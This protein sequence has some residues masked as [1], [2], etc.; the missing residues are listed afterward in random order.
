MSKHSQPPDTPSKGPRESALPEPMIVP[1]ARWVPSLVW[2]ILLVAASIS[3]GLAVKSISNRGPAI[4]ISFVNAEGLEPGK[5]KV[6]Y[7]D[8]NIGSVE[9]I[10]LSKDRLRVLV[11]VQLRRK[12]RNSQSRARVSGP[13]ARASP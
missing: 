4:T 5:S 8:V 10:T 2:L 7:K 12:P 13:S 6:E 1:R 3:I 11:N 9:T